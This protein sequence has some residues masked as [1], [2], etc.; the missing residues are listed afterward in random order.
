MDEGHATPWK[1]RQRKNIYCQLDLMILSTTASYKWIQS[2]IAA[3][4][5]VSQS[6][7]TATY[8][9][10]RST[11]FL[12]FHRYRY[13]KNISVAVLVSVWLKTGYRYRYEKKS[14]Y[15]YQYRYRYGIPSI[16]V[17]HLTTYLSN[18]LMNIVI[19]SGICGIFLILVS[20]WI[21]LKILVSVW[22][23]ILG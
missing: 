6:S 7:P 3:T 22:V 16:S 20:V 10:Q 21:F 8:F 2:T 13:Q 5:M 9:C 15:L 1:K 18:F 19:A 14:W 17:W 12:V 23:S 4:S 11:C